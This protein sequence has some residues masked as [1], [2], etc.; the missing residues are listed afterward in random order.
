ML[1]A[2]VFAGAA[3]ALYGEATPERDRLI[4]TPDADVIDALGGDDRVWAIGGGEGTAD[5]GSPIYDV[6]RGENGDD[7]LYGDR[8]PFCENAEDNDC[9][10]RKAIRNLGFT[11]GPEDIGT[12]G[13]DKLLGANGADKLYGNE[14]DDFLS[15]GKGERVTPDEPF[16]REDVLEGG[17][18]AD[19]FWV[20][21][22]AYNNDVDTITD[23]DTSEGDTLNFY[24]N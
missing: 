4:G 8:S 22:A 24:G 1:A 23:L 17:P 19:E 5:D 3:L 6:V 14:G 11:G 15:A 12:A 9:L 2:M 21:E 18:D 10:T 20:D 13:R 16:G 7:R